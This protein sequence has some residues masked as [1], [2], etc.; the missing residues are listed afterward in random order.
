MNRVDHNPS[1]TE[2]QRLNR[3][4]D[5]LGNQIDTILED[6]DEPL[7][8]RRRR[9]REFMRGQMVQVTRTEMQVIVA[10]MIASVFSVMFAVKVLTVVSR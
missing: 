6:Q 1:K 7:P 5:R 8:P 4:S 2:I 3:L 9:F 10:L